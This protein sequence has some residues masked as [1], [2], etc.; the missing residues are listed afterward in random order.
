[1]PYYTILDCIILK[2][3][4]LFLTLEDGRSSAASGSLLWVP[5]LPPRR[6][7]PPRRRPPG[8]RG[9][10]KPGAG[11]TPETNYIITIRIIMRNKNNNIVVDSSLSINISVY[12]IYIL[13]ICIYMYTVVFY[14]VLCSVL[15]V[16]CYLCSTLVS[17]KL[18]A[19]RSARGVAPD[20]LP[21]PRLL[22]WGSCRE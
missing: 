18:W 1:M 8:A 15:R 10:S 3:T 17:D 4:M 5:G 13:Y 2:C 9:L 16:S 19:F 22:A 11:E 20:R 7:A 21:W 6:G 14:S 12:Y